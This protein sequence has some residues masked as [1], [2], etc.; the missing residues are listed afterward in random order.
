MIFGCPRSIVRAL[1][2]IIPV[3]LR[4][5]I[6]LLVLQLFFSRTAQAQENHAI[7]IPIH[8]SQEHA[9]VIIASRYNN[10]LDLIDIG[11]NILHKGTGKRMEIGQLKSKKLRVSLVP[12]VGYTLQTN[13]AGLLASNATFYTDESANASTILTSLTY[14]VRNQVILPYQTTIWTKDNKYNIVFDWRYLYF[15]SFTYGLG[16]YT[17]LSDGYL[18]NYSALNLHQAVL[19][20]V[21]KNMYAGL[22]YNFNYYWDIREMNPPV[23]MLSDFARYG[24][25][26]KDVASGITLNFLYDTRDNPVSAE[27]GSFVDFIYRTNPVFLGN[28]GGWQSLIADI[29]K[30]IKF[31]EGSKNVIALW[32]YNWITPGGKPPYLMLPATGGDAYTNTGRGYIQGRFRGNNM[33]YMESEYRF[34]ITRD[35]FLGGVVFANAQTFTEQVSA[36]FET[37]APGYGGGLRF[38]FNKFSRT[39]VAIDYGFGIGGSGGVFVNVGEVF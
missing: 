36:R 30:F 20:R 24:Y 3:S 35:G 27:K 10:E 9:D 22:G 37:I 2:Y 34:R 5:G 38:K 16:G 8:D 11:R 23:G 6:A 17:S 26:K 28:K 25:S 31:P 21:M 13:F 29:R 4:I 39:S 15:P 12:A 1:L 32:S 14:T 18:V 33:L 7:P 19:R